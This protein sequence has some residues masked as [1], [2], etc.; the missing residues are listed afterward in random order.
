[1][2]CPNC[3][4]IIPDATDYCAYCGRGTRRPGPPAGPTAGGIAKGTLV[5]LM[6]LIVCALVVV[7]VVGLWAARAWGP[8]AS[9]VE[10]ATAEASPTQVAPVG[11][12]TGEVAGPT[13]GASPTALPTATAIPTPTST[14][15]PEPEQI[16]FP[17]PMVSITMY[18]EPAL[19]GG[20]KVRVRLLAAGEPFLRETVAIAAAARDIAGNWNIG[21]GVGEF[22]DPSEL[23][24]TVEFVREPG[25]YAVW[26]D[27]FGWC[28]GGNYGIEGRA[29]QQSVQLIPVSVQAGR[30][31]EIEI[32]FAVLEVGLLTEQG[33]AITEGGCRA[34]VQE[35]DIAGQ[36]I[37]GFP[38]DDDRTDARGVVTLVLPAGTY[39][40]ECNDWW[41]GGGGYTYFYDVSVQVGERKS[42]VYTVPD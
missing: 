32:S 29:G 36:K 30:V 40:L 2:K 13:Q 25:D 17:N 35:L 16:D 24:G 23:D 42:V 41:G 21:T 27:W 18:D 9:P 26:L 1:M 11:R 12:G 37:L 7:G 5:A 10:Q 3:G 8:T 39:V 34:S 22:R 20:G 38:A 14:S 33:N 15:A 28:S 4:K 6:S 31:T 19:A